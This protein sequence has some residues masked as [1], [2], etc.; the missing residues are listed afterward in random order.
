M[1]SQKEMYNIP[2]GLLLIFLAISGNFLAQTLGCRFQELMNENMIVKYILILF[3]IYFTVNYT[4]SSET[5]PTKLLL[6]T[7]FVWLFFILLARTNIYFTIIIFILL[8][9][10]YTMNNYIDYY[11]NLIDKE[12][13]E[14][15]KQEYNKIIDNLHKAYYGIEITT[16]SLLIIGFVIYFIQKY[17]EYR[18]K[19][20]GFNIGT[21]IFGKVSCRKSNDK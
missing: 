2:K 10:L 5:S 4:S 19:E 13:D 17:L 12:S 21:F 1:L 9:T 16:I 15:K 8:I 6:L 14:N 20:G 3:I 18:G 7:V 11:K